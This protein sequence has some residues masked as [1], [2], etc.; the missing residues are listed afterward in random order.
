MRA[1]KSL[2]HGPK[3]PSPNPGPSALSGGSANSWTEQ[4]H[5]WNSTGSMP[6]L[7]KYPPIL[8]KLVFDFSD[9]RCFDCMLPA[10][11]PPPQVLFLSPP[12]SISLQI[13]SLANVPE[14]LCLLLNMNTL[15]PWI[16]FI[17]FKISSTSDYFTLNAQ[18]T[19]T[20]N[21]DMWGIQTNNY[22]VK[23]SH[24]NMCH[25]HLKSH[26]F[27]LTFYIKADLNY[28]LMLPCNCKSKI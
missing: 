22:I 10:M 15:T 19:F 28:I 23:S 2:G 26:S 14:S 20:C 9:M 11:T 27:F 25:L 8:H 5:C 7:C 18:R 3:E 24:L 12:C 17:I 1:A 4:Q 16:D 6:Q 13:I 21:L